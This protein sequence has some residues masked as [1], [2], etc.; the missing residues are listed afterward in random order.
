MK[1]ESD[2]H[3]KP[4]SLILGDLELKPY[5]YKEWLDLDDYLTI[6]A[7]I[8]L[9]EDQYVALGKLKNPIKVIRHGI[10]E[11]PRKMDLVETAWSKDN[12]KSKKK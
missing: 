4:E 11:E 8:L 5:Q 1:M 2:A 6:A 10:D 7:R 12:G 3:V 9:S